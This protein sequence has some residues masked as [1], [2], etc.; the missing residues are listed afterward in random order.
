MMIPDH[1]DLRRIT[2]EART[3]RATAWL[4]TK[5]QTIITVMASRAHE[6]YN[7]AFLVAPFFMPE[8]VWT[9]I[10]M[11]LRTRLARYDILARDDGSI[12]IRW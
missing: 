6:G 2:D 10:R 3:A 11:Q 8:H 5:M 1:L 9:A 4:D 7:N 12:E